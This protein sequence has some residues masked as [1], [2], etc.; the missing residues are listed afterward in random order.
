MYTYGWFILKFDRKQQN[1]VKQLS[2]NKKIFK[3]T[4]IHNLRVNFMVCELYLKKDFFKKES[5]DKKYLVS[6]TRE[7]K[8]HSYNL[9]NS[10]LLR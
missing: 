2:Y 8:S 10:A 7:K 6:K 3:N 5:K 9:Y 4:V 1:S